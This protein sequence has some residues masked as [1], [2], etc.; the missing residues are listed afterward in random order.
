MSE[1]STPAH[2][3]RVAFRSRPVTDIVVFHH[4]QGLTSGMRAFAD[5][6]RA[7]GHRVTAPD[8]YDGRTF[9]S[10]T[11]GIAHSEQIGFEEILARGAAAVA[12]IPDETIFIGFSLGVMPAQ[13]LAQTRAGAAGA[14]LIHAAVP[15]EY[16][17]PWPRAVPLQLHVME[18]DALGDVDVARELSRTI[19][20]AELFLY[21]GDRHLFTDRSLVEY[22]RASAALVTERVLSFVARRSA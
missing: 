13:K 6:L 18:H 4:A 5:E 8:L 20:G 9:E 3:V 7:T 15:L 19:D 11:A 2:D 21:P 1:D 10:L 22:D 12:D 14:I 16:F 17:G